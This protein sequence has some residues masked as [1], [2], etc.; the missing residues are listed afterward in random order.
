MSSSSCPRLMVSKKSA[1]PATTHRWPTGFE[2]EPG[3]L[4]ATA[5]GRSTSV[6]V[7]LKGDHYIDAPHLCASWQRQQLGWR[8]GA[9]LFGEERCKSYVLMVALMSSVATI[10]TITLAIGGQISA[11][12]DMLGIPEDLAHA[13]AFVES[14][15]IPDAVGFLGE[16]GLSQ[17][18]PDTV[19]WLAPMYGYTA[20]QACEDPFVNIE[21][22]QRYLLRQYERF[23]DWDL[24]LSAYN[25]G[26]GKVIEHE[27]I[28]PYTQGY[29]DKV[30][31]YMGIRW[32]GY[33]PE[34]ESEEVVNAERCTPSCCAQ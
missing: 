15:G 22:G 29:V 26:P 5:S 24:A 18:H 8:H 34:V 27:G 12:A 32:P 14:W 20:Q 21:L 2:Q 19:A 23:D 25:A 9:S 33:W 3:P 17:L 28:A 13:Q 7:P 11:Q 30:H 6:R 10:I 31:E 16:C 1:V 4:A